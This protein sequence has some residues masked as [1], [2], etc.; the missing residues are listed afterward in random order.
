MDHS[1]RRARITG[2]TVPDQA[3]FRAE[4]DFEITFANGG[5]LSGEGFRIDIAGPDLGDAELGAALITDLGLLMA[6]EVRISQR[7]I[8]PDRHKRATPPATSAPPAMSAPPATLAPP[9]MSAPP[10]TL[11]PP[12]MSAPPA[13]SAPAAACAV[14]RH[15][16]LSH[17]IKNGMVTIPGFPAPRIQAQS[18]SA[19][20]PPGRYAPGVSFAIGEISLCGNTSTY[21]DSPRHLLPDGDDLAALSLDRLADLDG[22]VID[23]TGMGT[24]SADAASADAASAD[25][26]SADG[27]SADGASADGASADGADLGGAEPGGAGRP[28]RGIGPGLLLPYDVA[29]KAV[30]L[31]T[32]W[33]ARWGSAEYHAGHPFLTAAAAR[34]LADAGAVLVGIDAAN[35]D[36]TGDPER[37]AHAILLAAGVGICEHLTGLA[38]LPGSGFRFSAVPPKVAA[39]GTFP[40]RA[41]ATWS[42]GS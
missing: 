2:M 30:L 15:A 7:R 8:Y 29:G 9:A 42:A 27:A 31:R 20:L 5:R 22:I 25:G 32:G 41:Y 36:D 6:D 21:L 17:V 28:G 39:F 26:A 18:V 11:A 13:T 16:D 1:P 10:A 19:R 33:D 14:V 23:L 3:Q 40:V 35:V 12:A 37:P 34:H 24:A 38:A 4:L